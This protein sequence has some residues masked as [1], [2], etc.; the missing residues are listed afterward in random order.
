MSV[1]NVKDLVAFV[2]SFFGFL[3]TQIDIFEE[4][5]SAGFFEWVGEFAGADGADDLADGLGTKIGDV[6]FI[7]VALDGGIEWA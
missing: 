3:F 2:L 4:G 1:V 7:D 6:V 5:A